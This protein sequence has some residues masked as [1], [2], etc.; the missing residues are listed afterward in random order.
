MNTIG[1]RLDRAM[2]GAKI[3]SQAELARRSG[4]PQ[5]TISRILK[6]PGKKGPETETLRKLANACGVRF[7]WL[8]EGTGESGL[9]QAQG[10]S[11]EQSSLVDEILEIAALYREA[12]DRE[13]AMIMNAARLVR[14]NKRLAD[15]AGNGN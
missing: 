5:P 15:N 6:D 7:E 13:R 4:V 11:Q 12:S 14:R 10:Q 3:E 9:G 1:G 2:K 8:N